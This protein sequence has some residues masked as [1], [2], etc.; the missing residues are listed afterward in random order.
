MIAAL[1]ASAAAALG[2]DHTP[3][4]RSLDGRISR[5]IGCGGAWHWLLSRASK[6]PKI[7]M[8]TTTL[9]SV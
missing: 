8:A 7:K 1:A 5:T 9:I 2:L 6:E 4:S 3:S